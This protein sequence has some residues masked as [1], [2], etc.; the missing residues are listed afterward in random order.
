MF[1]AFSWRRQL[2][3]SLRA[4]VDDCDNT[5]SIAMTGCP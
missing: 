4:S 5:V 3:M 1:N 2:A